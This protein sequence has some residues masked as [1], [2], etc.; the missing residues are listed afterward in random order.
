MRRLLVPVALVVALIAAMAGP[1]TAA[2]VR[3]AGEWSVEDGRLVWRAEQ[4]IPIGDAAVEF[5]SGEELLGRPRTH[6]DGRTFSLD[7]DEAGKLADLSVRAAGKRLDAAAP[8]TARRAAAVP[9]APAP[10]PAAAVDPGR[11]GPYQSITGEYDLPGVRLP[12]LPEKVEMRAVVVAP[13]GAAGPRPLALFLHGRHIFCYRGSQEYVDQVW[14]CPADTDPVPSH[15]GYLQ[16]QRLLASQG[17]VTVSISANG[18]NAQDGDIEDYGAQAR[19]SL[20]RWHLAKWA[21]WAGAGRASAPDIVRAAPRAE[22]SRVFLMGHSRGGEGV[23]RAAMDSL[24]PPPGDLVGRARWTVRGLLLIGPTIF[25]HDPVPD[26]PSV[27]VL[28]GCDGDVFDLQGQ[29][30]VDETRG[31]S[32]GRA[33]HSAL[34]VVGANH[35]FFN[36]E[37]TPGQSVAPSVDD[38]FGGDE[39]D[40]VCAP[41]APTRLT[42]AQQQTVGATY[43][44]AAA[45]LFVAGDDRV[46]PLLDG[47][48]VRAPS[49]GPARVYSHALGGN[50]RQV[51]AAD[52]AV[53]T[54]GGARIC[55][56][57]AAVAARSCLDPDD[58]DAQL[59]HFSRFGPVQPEPG[60]YAAELSWSAAGTPMR[61]TVP[62]PVA[63]AGHRALA[64]RVIVPPNTTGTTFGVTAIGT[65]GRRAALGDVRL[66][67]LPGTE[68]TA[69][70]WAQEVR[71]P[72]TGAPREVA[73]LEFTPRTGAGR[74]WLLDAWAWSPG[75]PD[76][77][78]T[79]LP[80]IDIGSLAVAEGDSGSRTY[81]IPV[82]VTGRGGGVVRLFLLDSVSY[83]TQSWLATV[84]PGDREVRVPVEVTGDPLWGAD[85]ASY[86]FAKA[87]RGLVI[88]D[89]VGDAQVRNDDPEPAVSVVAPAARVAEGGELTWQLKLSAPVETSYYVLATPRAPATGAEL[90]STDVDPDWFFGNT[91]EE[92]EPSRPLSGTPLTI[93]GEVPPGGGTGEITLPT[94]TDAVTEPDEVVELR[95]GE[96]PGGAVLTGVV[97]GG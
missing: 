81:A 31:V 52:P 33:L 57:V 36:T 69:S 89:Y 87:E 28:P 70:Y 26:V 14:P 61:L 17:Y 16:A 91:W 29:M 22:M 71:V 60:R 2:P 7:L 96:R 59:T 93:W 44:A 66:D 35:N 56:Q 79:A 38:F 72:L 73:A 51:L 19:S 49:A 77:R 88:G 27:T 11:P 46:R 94:V 68:F 41:G 74:A 78:T 12:G 53:R 62:R 21:D 55:E 95:L 15:R 37:W 82:S 13:R 75:T 84:R 6:P 39:P 64:L 58:L 48:G 83:E 25:G 8:R 42:A 47:S 1:V 45:R 92:P 86:L 23:S 18:V 90:S 65:D 10:Q 24:T 40:A 63:V 54:T 43:I 97:T 85:E 34:Y 4:R 9:A 50:R 20:V 30:F 80:R 3:P 32:K 5:F 67:G 76:P